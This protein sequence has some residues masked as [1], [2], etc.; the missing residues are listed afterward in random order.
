MVYITQ[1]H[2]NIYPLIIF[3]YISCWELM[4]DF[5]WDNIIIYG[6]ILINIGYILYYWKKDYDLNYGGFY[7]AIIVLIINKIIYFNGFIIQDIAVK[8]NGYNFLKKY[9]F[10][11]INGEG[12]VKILVKKFNNEFIIDHIQPMAIPEKSHRL[13]NYIK[14]IFPH[15]YGFFYYLITGNKEYFSHYK[16]FNYLGIHYLGFGGFHG[17]LLFRWIILMFSIFN[18]VISHII[19][20]FFTFIILIFIGSQDYKF[21]IILCCCR[22]F[23]KFIHKFFHWHYNKWFWWALLFIIFHSYDPLMMYH[24]S[25][26]MGFFLSLFFFINKQF[27]IIFCYYRWFFLKHTI[28]NLLILT[29]SI[30]FFNF[31]STFYFFYNIIFKD[32]FSFMIIF[33][34]LSLLL[35]WIG[36]YLDFLM[37]WTIPGVKLL[38]KYNYGIN[39]FHNNGFNKLILFLFFIYGIFCLKFVKLMELLLYLL[40]VTAIYFLIFLGGVHLFL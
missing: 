23:L 3:F 26:I 8:K 12:P 13:F 9:F 35:P 20:Y 15:H 31:F 39:F 2:Y 29:F 37:G 11:K 16:C 17:N 30:H 33:T 40:I 28:L 38:L 5:S 27:F 4:V 14:G 22:F 7:G 21:N 18:P 19:G 10:I 34:F 6:F 32:Y 36:K 1:P 25:F 24:P